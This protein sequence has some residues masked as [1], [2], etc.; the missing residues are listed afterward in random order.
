MQKILVIEDTQSLRRDV[1]DILNYEGF[2]VVDAEDGV[3]GV[4]QAQQH[5]PDLILCDI[6]MPGKDGYSVLAELRQDNST[7]TIPF[8]FMTAKTD[9]VDLRQGMEMGA[10]DFITK[11]FTAG[12]LVKA[13]QTQLEKHAMV[14]KQAERKL[15]DL[16]RA[17]ILALPHEL[18]TP[19]NVILGFSD[20]MMMDAATLEPARVEDMARHINNSGM[21]LY[22]LIE[23]YLIYAQLELARADEA[24][25]NTLRSPVGIN[26]QVI[27]E[28]RS[29][30]MAVEKERATDLQMEVGGT[31]GVWISEDYVR[32]ITEELLEN[33]F[34][35]S[36]PG[37]P[38]QVQAGGQ[39]GFFSLCVSNQGRGMTKEQIESIGAYMQFERRVYE[40]QGSGLGLVIARRFAEMHDGSLTIE[41]TP[42]EWTTVCVTLPIR[43]DLSQGY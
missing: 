9:R 43:S 34:K 17:I 24:H 41:S 18:R 14:A 26:P 6:M 2:D 27:I 31:D 19:L 23:H 30:A 13:V 16:R 8:I 1:V 12:E 39:N 32:R 38:V 42:G 37:T 5:L 4:E 22:R 35:F 10:S 21:R 15:D 3:I 20:L 36:Q 33:A 11:P 40:Q 7:A 25:L 28:E 29:Q